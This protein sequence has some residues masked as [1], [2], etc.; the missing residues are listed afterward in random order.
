MN[1]PAQAEIQSQP[2]QDVVIILRECCR[3]PAIRVASDRRILRDGARNANQ[4]IRERV[5][6]GAIV[7]GE[8]SVIVQQRLLN[9]LVE[10]Q[11]ATHFQRVLALRQ[12]EDIAQ[13]IEVG[14]G[15]R[16]P[17]CIA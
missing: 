10:R 9:V 17:N 8:H 1:I 12:T 16:P 4:E 2:R 3:V 5:L 15:R 13:R 14:T 11:L 7:E 6:R